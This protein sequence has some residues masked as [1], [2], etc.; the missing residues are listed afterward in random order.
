METLEKVTRLVI[1]DIEMPKMNGIEATKIAISKYPQLKILI[2]SPCIGETEYYNVLLDYGIKGFLPKD[3]DNEEFFLAI[4][5]IL[6]V[7][8]MLHRNFS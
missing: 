3:A 2:L 7:K 1:M 4:N 5:K 6:P 8:L